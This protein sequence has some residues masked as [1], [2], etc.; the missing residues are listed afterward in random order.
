MIFDKYDLFA[1]HFD[2]I[3]VIFQFQMVHCYCM[4]RWYVGIMGLWNYGT[5]CE[6]WS[7]NIPF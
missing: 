7:A 1:Y 5:V 4:V 2:G 3:S 6:K